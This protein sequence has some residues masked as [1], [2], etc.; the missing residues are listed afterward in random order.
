MNLIKAREYIIE[1]LRKELDTKFFYHRFEHTLD[2]TEAA[3]RLANMEKLDNHSTILL[4]TAA[5]YHD[6]GILKVYKGHEIASAELVLEVLPLFDYKED[7]IK[8]VIEIILATQLPQTPKNILEQIICDADLDY[9]GR[10]D[11]Y[12]NAMNLYREWTT[13]GV[14]MSLKEWYVLQ[15]EFMQNHQYFTASSIMLRQERKMLH[16]AQLKELVNIKN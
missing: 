9:L 11:F 4:Q 1:R 8:I 7:E 5:L 14:Q 10:D 13:H 16:L 3:M 12:V 6:S 15:V 2:V